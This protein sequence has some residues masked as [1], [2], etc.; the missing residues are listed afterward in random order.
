MALLTQL[1]L[2]SVLGTLIGTNVLASVEWQR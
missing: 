2:L 1:L